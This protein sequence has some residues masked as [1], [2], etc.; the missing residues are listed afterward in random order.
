MIDEKDLKIDIYRFNRDK[1]DNIPGYDTDITYKQM[2]EDI[3]TYYTFWKT[4]GGVYSI[5]KIETE[6]ETLDPIK[7]IKYLNKYQELEVSYEKITTLTE[8]E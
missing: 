3:S 1:S 8:R 4:M 7:L 2:Q 6:L 5:R